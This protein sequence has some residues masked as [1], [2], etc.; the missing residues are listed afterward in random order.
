MA[1][2]FLDIDAN[3][4]LD[5]N[6]IKKILVDLIEILTDKLKGSVSIYWC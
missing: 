2:E 1:F 4:Q 6:E 5:Y 3:T